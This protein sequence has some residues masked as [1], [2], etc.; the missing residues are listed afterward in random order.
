MAWTRLPWESR[1]SEPLDEIF[2]RRLRV[3]VLA[4]CACAHLDRC[5]IK[6][7]KLARRTGRG[8]LRERRRETQ[9]KVVIEAP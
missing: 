4:G 1:P 5:I 7:R 6:A 3:A 9:Y 8:S 2:M